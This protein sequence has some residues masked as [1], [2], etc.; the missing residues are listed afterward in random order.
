M[1]RIIVGMAVLTLLGV[2]PAA[3]ARRAPETLTISGK[4]L[5]IN[6]QPFIA[7]GVNYQPVPRTGPGNWPD[8]WTMNRAVVFSDLAKM[9][10]M[11]VNLIRVYVQY[12]RLFQNWDEQNDPSSDPGRVDQTVLANYRAV[13]DEADRQGIY[14]L[15]NY[16]LPTSVD[17]RVGQQ[18]KFN[19]DARTRH[20]LRF[21]NIINVFKNRTEF[22]MVLMWALGNENNFEW[23]RGQMT[24]EAMFDFLGEAIRE[25]D[26]QADSAH[27]YTVVL[28]DNPQLDIHNTSLLNRA[29]LVDVWSINMYNTE[30]GFKNIIQGYS[31]NKPLLF[32]EFGY[33]AC[34]HNKGCDFSNPE[35]RGT[36]E[37]QLQQAA[38]YQ[39]RWENAM[40]PNLSARSTANKLLGGV[41]FEWN[42]E[43]WKDGAGPRDV[44]DTGGFSNA[45]LTP[46]C[47]MNEEWFGLSTAL[48]DTETSGR[49]YRSAFTQLKKMWTA[50]A[51]TSAE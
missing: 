48:K 19:K 35:G 33:D 18:V 10:E 26:Q 36:Q 7:K 43:W 23:N 30:Q 8:D 27:P 16:F 5:L 15:M 13:L 6:G 22:P 40:L 2:A 24:S 46:D 9:K 12:D 3:H 50:P 28:G 21:R 45:N 11:G 34:Q 17:Y 44:H 32:T 1:Y 51:L 42:D 47:F 49:Y 4:Q 39:S 29:P 25:A 14:V 20:K 38:F 41:V 31:L 37:A